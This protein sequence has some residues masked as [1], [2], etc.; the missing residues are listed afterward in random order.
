MRQKL[1]NNIFVGIWLFFLA[2]SALGLVRHVLEPS[3]QMG[4]VLFSVA[5]VA[6]FSIGCATAYAHFRGWK[7]VRVGVA[8]LSLWVVVVCIPLS[9]GIFYAMIA[10]RPDAVLLGVIAALLVV[11]LSIGP[12]VLCFATLL[13]LLLRTSPSNS[14]VETPPCQEL[15]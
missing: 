8:L 7:Y 2:P 9:I 5:S 1:Y 3:G 15:A 12:D 6:Y 4:T 10:A 11:S 14:E 13:W